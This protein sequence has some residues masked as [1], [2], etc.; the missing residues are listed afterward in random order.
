MSLLVG[1][2][3]ACVS[4][5]PVGVLGASALINLPQSVRATVILYDL[6]RQEIVM[7]EQVRVGVAMRK[8]VVGIERLLVACFWEFY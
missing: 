7:V 3:I 6:A 5:P 2:I 4:G 1:F 8:L